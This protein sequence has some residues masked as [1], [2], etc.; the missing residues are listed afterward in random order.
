[1]TTPVVALSIA[2]SDSGGAAGIQADLKTF[3]ALGV[4]G[5]TAITALTAQSTTEV[6]GVHAV[7]AGFVVAQIEAVLDDLDVRAVKTGMLANAETVGAVADLAA[8]GRLSNL[9]VD[10]VMVAS[11]GARLLDA[12][13]E[14]VY[15]E[16]LLPHARV[17]TP[18]LLEAG[19][20]LGREITTLDDQRDAARELAEGGA[21]VVVV[22]GGHAVGDTP[23]HAVDVVAID[24]AV[25][26][27]RS[28]RVDTANN[29]GSGCS[30]ASA[31]AA[32]LALGQA[33]DVAIASAKD[34]VHRAITGGARWELGAGHGPLD[35]LGW[36]TPTT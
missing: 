19:A 34:F 28:P 7:P 17:V 3:A 20:L 9:V 35:H 27:L 15:V 6:R 11:S 33:P 21:E 23:G 32:G 10:P 30:F 31:V 26:E 25:R 14:R 1:V 16:R 2:G 4:F 12:E 22:K 24:G 5:T 29:H 13:A 18:N 36:E 8:A